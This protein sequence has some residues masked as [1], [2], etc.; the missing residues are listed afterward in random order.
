MSNIVGELIQDVAYRLGNLKMDNNHEFNHAVILRAM[1]RVYERLNEEY[2]VIE[3]EIT[4][5]DTN[6]PTFST[7]GY[8]DYPDDMIKIFRID[9]LVTFVPYEVYS[10]TENKVFSLYQSR[11]YF[12]NA[13]ADSEY[14]VSY[15]S[16]GYTLVDTEDANVGTGEVNTPEYQKHLRQI[17]MYGTAIEL[18]ADYPLRK[19]DKEN[20]EKLESGLYGIKSQPQLFTPQIVGPGEH[21]TLV[22]T[23]DPY[24]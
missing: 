14:D 20:F 9:P 16:M 5:N 10:S 18:K 7:N 1:R 23:L 2:Q 11:I 19:Q 4:V 17:L 15:Y 22:D 24:A 8:I 12:S 21:K 3:R 6:Y 13:S